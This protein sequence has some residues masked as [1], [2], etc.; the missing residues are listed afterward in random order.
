MV[1][2]WLPLTEHFNPRSHTGSDNG[3]IF[4]FIQGMISIHAPTRGATGGSG[5]TFLEKDE[6]QSTLPHG[7]RQ[8]KRDVAMCHFD[9]NPRSHTGSD[10]QEIKPSFCLY[11][12]IHAPTRGA[13]APDSKSYPPSSI[14]IHAPTRGA[15]SPFFASYKNRHISIHAP[16]RGATSKCFLRHF[17]REFQSTLPHGERLPRLHGLRHRPNISIHAP[18]RGATSSI[19]SVRTKITIFQ[20]TLPHGERQIRIFNVTCISD[21]N[22]RSHTGSDFTEV[23]RMSDTELFQSTLPHGERQIKGLYSVRTKSISIH[24]PT[25]GATSR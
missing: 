1:K 6:F 4:S 25:R 14:S 17:R 24:A 12:S 18:T 3:D 10:Y 15:T 5:K 13:T 2:Y 9:F 23:M 8:T 11:I 16:T 22:P 7:E 21:F 20:S 19:C